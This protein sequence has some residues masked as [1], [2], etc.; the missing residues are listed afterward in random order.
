MIR[1]AAFKMNFEIRRIELKST[2]RARGTDRSYPAWI[3]DLAD[4]KTFNVILSNDRI[5]QSY[6]ARLERETRIPTPLDG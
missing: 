3:F 5:E 4:D 1:R 2:S 6:L